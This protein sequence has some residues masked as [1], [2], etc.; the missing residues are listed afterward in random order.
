VTKAGGMV[1]KNV[2]G[3][4]LMRVYLGSVGTLGVVVS[5]NF[6]VLPLARHE[7]T[8][9]AAH[10]RMEDALAA[11][12]HVRQGRALPQ[13]LEVFADGDAW[14]TAVRIEGRPTTVRILSSEVEALLRG[15]TATLEA[16]ESKE[17]WQQYAN[18]EAIQTS[19]DDALLRASVR[20]KTVGSAA[21]RVWSVL[22][23]SNVDAPHFAVTPI[24]GQI[25]LRVRVFHAEGAPNAFTRLHAALSEAVENLT[26]VAAPTSWKRDI[27]VWGRMPTTI[28][29]MRSMKQAFDPE[30]VL[31]PGRFAGRI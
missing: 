4:D 27:D 5:A 28:D 23:D 24:A 29:V 7:A 16:S 13:S 21:Q 22:H 15:D 8:V 25:T 30:A 2:S 31:N 17:W 10:R 11:A 6:K 26:V 1:V 19:N 18:A 3:F 9:I 20:P 14:R 12:D